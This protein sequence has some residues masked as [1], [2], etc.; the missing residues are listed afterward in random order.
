M[1]FYQN[2]F[3]EYLGNYVV[4]DSRAFTL[5]FKVPQNRNHGEFFICWNA[6]NYDLSSNSD[7]TFNYAFD[8]EFKSWSSF[9]VDISGND[10]NQTTVYEIVSILNQDSTFSQFYTA[11][12]YKNSQVGIRQ[13]KPA[14]TFRTYI[15][16]TS[17]EIA[18]RFNKFAGIGDLPTYFEKDTIENRYL[19]PTA[20][21]HLIRIG[22]NIEHIS[23]DDSAEI[24]LP[25]HG[26]S[27]GDYVYI[28]NSNSTPN[29]DGVFEV[30]VTGDNT[31]TVTVTTTEEGYTGDIFTT[32]EYILLNDS[33][34]NWTS[35]QPDYKLLG[36][37]CGAYTTTLT[38]TDNS[39]RITS[40]LVY[41]TGSKAGMLGILTTNKYSTSADT[42]K[43]YNLT[44]AD[45]SSYTENM[46][47]I[48]SDLESSANFVQ[49]SNK[50]GGG[51]V[52]VKINDNS[53]AI[54]GL[55][56]G[57]TQIFD[58]ANLSFFKLS[59]ANS[60]GTSATIQVITSAKNMTPTQTISQ[61][62]VI[63]YYDLVSP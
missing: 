51:D 43:V 6:G 49:I 11:S 16:N 1:A 21:N 53:D 19:I 18:L 24:Y 29:V 17:A 46:C 7:L 31:F 42:I 45:G 57:D 26:L 39:N 23:V 37:R 47:D 2:L 60:S 52:E 10:P 35:V 14:S 56:A 3:N 4:G 40:Q 5:T 20:N 48:I 13:N 33:G 54:F 8:S 15:S 30:T 28:V 63:P 41:P 44:V 9:T 59:F 22:R 38:T 25:N 34:L 36:G 55:I 12:I 61:P 50:V 32:E 62:F 27:N 58:S